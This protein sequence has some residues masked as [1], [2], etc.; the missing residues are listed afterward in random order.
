MTPPPAS[1]SPVVTPYDRYATAEAVSPDDPSRPHRGQLVPAGLMEGASFP[2]SVTPT[3]PG[4]ADAPS[5]T[6]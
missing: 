5:T 1:D 6:R 3:C 2:A 4:R